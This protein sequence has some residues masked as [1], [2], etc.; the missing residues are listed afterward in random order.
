MDDEEFTRNTRENKR[1]N[2]DTQD[3]TTKQVIMMETYDVKTLYTNIP[4]ED[5]LLQLES[6]FQHIMLLNRNRELMIG[7]KGQCYKV[8]YGNRVDFIKSKWDHVYS[9]TDLK[10]MIEFLVNNTY[11]TLADKCFKQQIGIPMGTNSGVDIV[12]FYLVKYE[13]DFMAQLVSL[14]K[15]ELLTAFSG[16]MRYL[17]DILSV[18]NAVFERL[19]YNDI[20]FNGIK[21]IYP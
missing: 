5:L 7:H 14:G 11:V 10:N 21:G 17:D 12:D 8:L 19:L 13:Y 2:R 4:H 16:T 6:L 1:F 3:I 20:D 9:C 18:D 15:W